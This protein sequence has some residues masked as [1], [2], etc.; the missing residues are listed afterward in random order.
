MPAVGFYPIVELSPL[1][2]FS[3]GIH[4]DRGV[5]D[6]DGSV[7][8]NEIQRQFRDCEGMVVFPRFKLNYNV[9]LNEPLEALGMKR[10]FSADA[11]FSAMSAEKL[12]L[13]E[14]KQKSFVEVNDAGTEA[15][16]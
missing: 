9:V 12:F 11:D 5:T 13:S 7:C 1:S 16:Q 2:Q 15:R 14:V 10:A 4:A 6:F 8:Q 3:L